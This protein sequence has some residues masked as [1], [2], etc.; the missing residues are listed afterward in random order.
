M[1]L[2]DGV[3]NALKTMVLDDDQYLIPR[4]DGK[5]LAGSTVEH[6]Q[7]NKVTTMVAKEKLSEFA[8]N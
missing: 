2:F 3:P 6:D 8:I 5:I 4:R 1:L 7:F